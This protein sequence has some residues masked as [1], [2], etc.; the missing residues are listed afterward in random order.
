[1]GK[2]NRNG[3]WNPVEFSALSRTHAHMRHF[4]RGVLSDSLTFQ[5]AD[6]HRW[7]PSL[8][9]LKTLEIH[10]A[11]T[12]CQQVRQGGFGK[13]GYDKNSTQ[14]N[15]S[16]HRYGSSNSKAPKRVPD[17]GFKYHGCGHW[18]GLR[19]QWDRGTRWK[20]SLALSSNPLP[21][22]NGQVRPV[23]RLRETRKYGRA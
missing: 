7:T 11:Q 14:T 23:T 16:R 12:V 13:G 9:T 2:R 1:M 10:T 19:H 5:S 17:G 20:I 18:R 21:P 6:H 15:G 22:A 4:G 3:L 8:S